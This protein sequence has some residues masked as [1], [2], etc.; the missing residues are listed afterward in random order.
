MHYEGE[1]T[2]A[3]TGHGSHLGRPGALKTSGTVLCR[4]YG[5]GLRFGGAP[6]TSGIGLEA[7]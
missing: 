4:V 3:T 6:K 5:L 2:Q 7:I 1:A